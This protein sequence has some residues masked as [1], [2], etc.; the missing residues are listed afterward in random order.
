MNKKHYFLTIFFDSQD[1]IVSRK[2]TAVAI[3]AAMDKSQI[4]IPGINVI[5]RSTLNGALINPKASSLHEVVEAGYGT[6]QIL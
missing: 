2:V 4:P 5:E 3:D 6:F 1:S